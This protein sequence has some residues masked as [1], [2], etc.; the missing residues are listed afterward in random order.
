MGKFSFLDSVLEF[1]RIGPVKFQLL[2]AVLRVIKPKNIQPWVISYKESRETYAKIFN[3]FS[4]TGCYKQRF[5]STR[6]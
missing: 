5:Y 6:L 3:K 2:Q 4:D 1:N